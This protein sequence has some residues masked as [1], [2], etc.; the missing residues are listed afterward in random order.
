MATERMPC[1]GARAAP[2]SHWDIRGAAFRAAAVSS[3]LAATAVSALAQDYDV[4]ETS[5]KYLTVP[6]DATEL[7]FINPGANLGP[8]LKVALT[9]NPNNVV[10][11]QDDGIT[12]V[13]LPFPFAYYG[14]TYES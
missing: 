12:G 3:I 8:N 5:G 13:D 7:T 2:A 1:R 11:G 4:S 6:S 14:A 9:T 10:R